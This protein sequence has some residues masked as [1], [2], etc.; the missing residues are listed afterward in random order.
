MVK[1]AGNAELSVL[2]IQHKFLGIFCPKTCIM[3]V[4]VFSSLFKFLRDFPL[5]SEI[6]C[7]KNT[8]F[9]A[10]IFPTL[11]STWLMSEDMNLLFS[12]SDIQPS[13]FWVSEVEVSVLIIQHNFWVFFV[14]KLV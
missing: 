11:T 6:L 1:S 9:R 7:G 8:L 2:I 12:F 3:P 13:G 4:Q 10:G 14:P 5:F